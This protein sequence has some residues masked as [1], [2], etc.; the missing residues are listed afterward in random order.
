MQSLPGSARGT[1][2][3]K[4]RNSHIYQ[5]HDLVDV[6]TELAVLSAEKKFTQPMELAQAE[7]RDLDNSILSAR[8]EVNR[9]EHEI[10]KLQDDIK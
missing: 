9:K 10:K 4:V 2:P 7:Q 6:V 1:V 5:R 3:S 8:R